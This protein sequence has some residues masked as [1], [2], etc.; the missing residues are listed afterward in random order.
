M[1][2]VRRFA[3]REKALGVND[4]IL[5][6][7]YVE[8]REIEGDSGDAI[9][10]DFRQRNYYDWRHMRFEALTSKDARRELAGLAKQ[11]AN[12]MQKPTVFANAV[13]DT[14]TDVDDAPGMLELMAE[15]EDAMPM[16][17]AALQ[18]F[19]EEVELF[20]AI[21]HE[22]SD[23]ITNA[24]AKPKPS[25]AKLAVTQKYALQV[26]EPAARMEAL[27]VDYVDQVGRV[28]GAIE[29]MA[30]HIQLTDDPETMEAA[31]SLHKSLLVLVDE[32]RVGVAAIDSMI[33]SMSKTGSLSSTL[34]PIYNRITTSIRPVVESLKKFESWEAR[35]GE[36]LPES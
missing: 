36:S 35:I 7:Y 3:E 15:S 25:Q 10:S 16:M 19:S 12:R 20:G 4:L 6:L 23:A 33:E 31:R 34:R 30:S 1:D 17:A 13:I 18:G 28:D 14:M 26:K 27:A 32:A 9:A 24:A 5:P 29:A 8:A 2:E 22:A 11:I 21:T